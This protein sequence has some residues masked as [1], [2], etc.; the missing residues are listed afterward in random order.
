[1][2][3][4]IIFIALFLS[5]GLLQ[6]QQAKV[7]NGEGVVASKIIESTR[8]L[9]DKHLDVGAGGINQEPRIVL[10]EVEHLIFDDAGNVIKKIRTSKY[11]HRGLAVE[12]YIQELALK[13]IGVT[14]LAERRSKRLVTEYNEAIGK[15][16]KSIPIVPAELRFYDHGGKAFKVILLSSATVQ[17]IITKAGKKRTVKTRPIALVSENNKFALINNSKYEEEMGTH[18]VWSFSTGKFS[19]YDN[20]GT[21]LFE[22]EYPK[23]T[24]IVSESESDKVVSNSGIVNIM[25]APPGSEGGSDLVLYVYNKNGKELLALPNQNLTFTPTRI[26]GVSPNGE[27]IAVEVESGSKYYSMFFN[28]LTGAHW[29]SDATYIVQDINDTG[30]ATVEEWTYKGKTSDSSKS[31]VLPGL[32]KK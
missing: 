16:R 2:N 32:L 8:T 18:G 29:R 28:V 23:Y 9:T 31:L 1:M 3:T 26:L 5:G 17:T 19:V 12:S 20:S 10:E 24:S 25:T 7:A 22:K 4:R 13:K 11:G 27:Y 15:I 14:S 30:V 21:Q 6:A